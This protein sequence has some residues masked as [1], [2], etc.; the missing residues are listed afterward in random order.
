MVTGPSPL[1]GQSASPGQSTGAPGAQALPPVARLS[2]ASGQCLDVEHRDSGAWALT[3]ECGDSDQQRWQL[4]RGTSD[5]YVVT[6]VSTGKCLT[7][8]NGSRDD[9]ARILQVDCRDSAEQRWLVRWADDT[10]ALANVNSG[11]CAAVEGD[12]RLRQRPCGD[13]PGQRW[14]VDNQDPVQ[15]TSTDSQDPGQRWGTNG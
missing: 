11:M 14:S 2:T 15:P 12:G 7:A 9:G 6:S 1:P 4:N 5:Q 10:F 8:E 3:A 13:D